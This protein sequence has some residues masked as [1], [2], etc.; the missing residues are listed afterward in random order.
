M[1][2]I[3]VP[4]FNAPRGHLLRLYETVIRQTCGKF[5]LIFVDDCSQSQHYS[6]IIQDQRV[7]VI[8]KDNNTGPADSRNIGAQHAVYPTLFFTD[9]DCW[10]GRKTLQV[11]VDSI[12]GEDILVGDTVTEAATRLGSLVSQLG[13]PGGGGIGFENVWRVDAQA[14]T[15]SISSCNLAIRK[16]VFFKI[17]MF[18]WTFP[19]AGGE[20]TV[21]AKAAIAGGY[22]IKYVKQ[23]LVY[24]REVESFQRFLAW[25][26]TRGRGNYHI[27]RRLGKV[28]GFFRLRMW[29]FKNSLKRAGIWAP[30]TLCLIVLAVLYQA[31]GY[32][33]EKKKNAHNVATG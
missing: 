18:D 12:S 30:M 14:Y 33:I 28:G 26:I 10:L 17:G 19:V 9:S 16:D 7:R 2:S 4:C 23:Q 21:F 1:I 29:S 3:I 11:V 6:D 8:Y 20:D 31:K 24:H 25:Q 22:R 15:N 13:F 5:E 32:S 27:K